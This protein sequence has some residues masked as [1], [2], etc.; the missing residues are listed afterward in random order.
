MA[1]EYF[2]LSENISAEIFA[3]LFSAKMLDE[4]LTLDTFEKF[5]PKTYAAFNE[6]F[7]IVVHRFL[8]LKKKTRNTYMPTGN[9]MGEQQQCN[10]T[11]I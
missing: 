2:D 1:K 4:T 5:M 7:S 3:N 6:I 8:Q 9:Y 10:L 11:N